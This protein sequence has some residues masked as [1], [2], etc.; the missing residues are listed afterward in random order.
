MLSALFGSDNRIL[1]E[2]H[3]IECFTHIFFHVGAA[4]FLLFEHLAD[5][6][7]L[8]GLCESGDHGQRMRT[9][10]KTLVGQLDIL[11]TMTPLSFSAFRSP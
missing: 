7:I 4:V 5:R 1:F 3:F 8:L 11:E 10:M 6:R 9:I 2:P